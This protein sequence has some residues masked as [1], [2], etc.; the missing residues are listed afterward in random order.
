MADLNRHLDFKRWAARRPLPDNL[1]ESLW[2]RLTGRGKTSLDSAEGERG[3]RKAA[4]LLGKAVKVAA[5]PI[6]AGVEF[7]SGLA[8]AALSGNLGEAWEKIKEVVGVFRDVSDIASAG[9]AIV[10]IQKHKSKLAM[11]LR[12][13][14]NIKGENLK[15]EAIEGILEAVFEVDREVVAI[16]PPI[17]WPQAVNGFLEGLD[18][19]YGD[20]GNKTFASVL[21]EAIVKSFSGLRTQADL[22]KTKIGDYMKA[23]QSPDIQRIM[24]HVEREASGQPDPGKMVEPYDQD[25][26]GQGH[27]P[28]G[29]NPDP[30]Q[31][32]KRV[33]KDGDRAYSRYHGYDFEGILDDVQI[34]HDMFQKDPDAIE[35]MANL[36]PYPGQEKTGSWR[37]GF[38]STHRSGV[39]QLGVAYDE[40]FRWDAGRGMWHAPAAYD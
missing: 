25:S 3:G 2:D 39:P 32:K 13:V 5:N 31:T 24:H 8:T 7:F 22:L 37:Y 33:P 15:P 16:V 27:N 19:G 40:P 6:G 10:R 26:E 9:T 23:F 34:R 12:E 17:V 18:A 11:H 1:D 20:L 38:L 28:E 4:G 35:G 14:N 36:I 21:Y 29:G 30:A